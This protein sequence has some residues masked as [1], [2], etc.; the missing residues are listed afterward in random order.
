[1]G[2]D[3]EDDEEED[4]EEVVVTVA[5]LD[6]GLRFPEPLTMFEGEAGPFDEE[7]NLPLPLPGGGLERI[8]PDALVLPRPDPVEA[9]VASPL[10]LDLMPGFF[11]D[12]GPLAESFLPPTREISFLI[13]R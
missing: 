9:W 6:G 2:L 11:W 4:E 5:E 10:T 1:M 8:E 7:E 12:M 13:L 3:E